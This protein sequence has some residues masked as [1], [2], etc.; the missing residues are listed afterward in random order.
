MRDPNLGKVRIL[1]ALVHVAKTGSW[2]VA[3]ALQ[4]EVTR[5]QGLVGAD[6]LRRARKPAKIL[7][8]ADDLGS[9]SEEESDTP[10]KPPTPSP[11]K[12]GKARKRGKRG[13]KKKKD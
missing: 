6:R 13:A 4:S 5:D 11:K 1:Q 3:E 10:E 8:W 12:K 2:R 7:S 9:E